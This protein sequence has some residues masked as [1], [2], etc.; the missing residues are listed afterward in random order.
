[1]KTDTALSDDAMLNATSTALQ[2]AT[3]KKYGFT[4]AT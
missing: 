1:M 3:L 2:M 4:R